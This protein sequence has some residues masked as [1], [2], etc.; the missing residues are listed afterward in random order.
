M[1]T[2]VKEQKHNRKLKAMNAIKKIPPSFLEIL[3]VILTSIQESVVVH[4]AS[5]KVVRS[6]HVFCRAFQINAAEVEG[7]TI[8][9]LGNRQ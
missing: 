4:D 2:V 1:H 9:D 7:I 6:N 8:Y 5:F 3:D